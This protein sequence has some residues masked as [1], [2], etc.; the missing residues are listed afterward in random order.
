MPANLAPS[1]TTWEG[2][3]RG[4]GC[5]V[6]GQ[7]EKQVGGDREQVNPIDTAKQKPATGRTGHQ[8]WAIAS[9]AKDKAISDDI[10]KSRWPGRDRSNMSSWNWNM[11]APAGCSNVATIARQAQIRILQAL[12]RRAANEGLRERGPGAIA[13]AAGRLCPAHGP[14]LDLD[15]RA[16]QGRCD[17]ADAIALRPAEVL[18]GR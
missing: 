9:D 6:D 4:F 13:D 18:S 8:L 3:T 5:R 1:S 10:G 12:S 16:R 15:G 7:I 14:A 2:R 11:A 17:V